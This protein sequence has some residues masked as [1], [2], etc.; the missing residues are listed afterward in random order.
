MPVVESSCS[1]W[2]KG[3]ERLESAW[4][5][6]GAY[7]RFCSVEE[8]QEVA[9]RG[10]R[11]GTTSE[12]EMNACG[13]GLWH[14]PRRS[15]WEVMETRREGADKRLEGWPKDLGT[16]RR[17]KNHDNV[18]AA[19]S[20]DRRMK[21][22]LVPF[23]ALADFKWQ[24]KACPGRRRGQCPEEAFTGALQLYFQKG[25][26]HT[27]VRAAKVLPWGNSHSRKQR[28]HTPGK[29]AL[30]SVLIPSEGISKARADLRQNQLSDTPRSYC[31]GPIPFVEARRMLL[32]NIKIPRLEL[33][34]TTGTTILQ[35]TATL[36]EPQ[37]PI[38]AIYPT[39][40]PHVTRKILTEN[41]RMYVF[42]PM[43]GCREALWFFHQ[44]QVYSIYSSKQAMQA[45]R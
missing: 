8:S 22:R 34:S 39:R 18:E 29:D 20:G 21:G 33:W 14:P 30:R 6:F 16:D 11:N 5:V 27:S 26:T 32:N 3:L 23:G 45:Q 36:V 7:F 1:E 40:M 41:V 17:E 44:H 42:L 31:P 37:R 13:Q 43:A 2:Q 24:R 35:N 38:K 19:G 25:P 10:G 15:I 4:Q 9:E 28:A 12:W